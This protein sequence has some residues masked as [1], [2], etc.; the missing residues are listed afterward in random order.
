MSNQNSAN[1]G[2]GSKYGQV[3]V[4]VYEHFTSDQLRARAEAFNDKLR[5][6]GK[7]ANMTY[8]TVE[9]LAREYLYRRA[10]AKLR[11][12]DEVVR[13]SRKRYNQLRAQLIKEL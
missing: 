10:Y 4:N 11:N 13:A 9:S 3:V 8:E 5:K 7:P 1:R 12:K 6:E 2:N